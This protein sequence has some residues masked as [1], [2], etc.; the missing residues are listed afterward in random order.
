MILVDQVVGQLRECRPPVDAR[1][2]LG[3]GDLQ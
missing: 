3:G 2:S 1:I